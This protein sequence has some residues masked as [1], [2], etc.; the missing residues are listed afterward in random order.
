MEIKKIDKQLYKMDAAGACGV[1][2]RKNV[3]KKVCK[4]QA[5]YIQKLKETLNE[6]TDDLIAYNWAMGWDE[7][8]RGEAVYANYIDEYFTVS[9]RIQ[10]FNVCQPIPAEC[11]DTTD[12]DA[13]RQLINDEYESQFINRGEQ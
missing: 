4:L 5:D 3:M 12:G 10:H 6:H 9:H 2:M 11:Y 7:E 8:K 1:L 13:V